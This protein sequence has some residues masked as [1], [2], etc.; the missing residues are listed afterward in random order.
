M[1]VCGSQNLETAITKD[2]IKRLEMERLLQVPWII[3]W[4]RVLCTGRS[5]HTGAAITSWTNGKWNCNLVCDCQ[6]DNPKCWLWAE[7]LP[8]AWQESW[9][10]SPWKQ[11][12]WKRPSFQ[13]CPFKVSSER[14]W[15]AECLQWVSAAFSLTE[16]SHHLRAPREAQIQTELKQSPSWQQIQGLATGDVREIEW[17]CACQWWSNHWISILGSII[18]IR[19][20]KKNQYSS[21]MLPRVCGFQVEILSWWRWRQMIDCSSEK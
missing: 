3:A 10:C 11:R 4:L 12:I 17:S 14:W 1:N 5:L 21:S 20:K 15:A 2:S 19:G 18:Q 13:V 9:H 16:N 7:P 8:S 6:E